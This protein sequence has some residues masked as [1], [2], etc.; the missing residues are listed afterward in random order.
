LARAL[1]GDPA[2]IILDEPD[3]H[4]D[5]AGEQALQQ[6]IT[7]AK[8][9]GAAIILVAQRPGTIMLMDYLLVLQQGKT[10]QFGP[11]VDVLR[12]VMRKEQ[13]T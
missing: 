11:R 3:A 2:L 13:G 5:Q 12:T 8:N 6:A 1:F 10:T 9:R 7:A 4:L